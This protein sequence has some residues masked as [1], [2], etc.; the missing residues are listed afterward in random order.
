MRMMKPTTAMA[1]IT[2]RPIIS[3]LARPSPKPRCEARAARPR[4][5]ARPAIGP[6]HLLRVDAAAAAGAAAAAPGAAV[7]VCAGV[8]VGALAGGALW[9]CMPKD[10]PPPMRRASASMATEDRPMAN[11]MASRERVFFMGSPAKGMGTHGG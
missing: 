7:G 9:R 1:A 2:S 5:A 6:I 4:P 11:T 10:L 8:A 3:M